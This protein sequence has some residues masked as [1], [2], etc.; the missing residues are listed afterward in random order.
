[1]ET[2]C[3]PGPPIQ[4]QKVQGKMENASD[5]QGTKNLGTK[6]KVFK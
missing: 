3:E 6:I 1:V 4:T 2:Q 5:E